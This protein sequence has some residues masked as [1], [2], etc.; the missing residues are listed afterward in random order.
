MVVVPLRRHSS[1]KNS[2]DGARMGGVRE[3]LFGD[4]GVFREP[5]EQLLAVGADDLRLRVVHV[6]VDEPGQDQRVLAVLFY[7][8]ARRQFGTD[9]G[10]GPEMGDLPVG[11]CRSMASRS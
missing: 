4:E 3:L 2:G 9:A 11:T 10:G 5:V 8:R 6:A 7:M 1:R